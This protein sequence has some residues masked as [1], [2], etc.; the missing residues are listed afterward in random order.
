MLKENDMDLSDIKINKDVPIDNKF[1]VLFKKVLLKELP[2]YKALIKFEG[3]RP[4]SDYL[5]KLHSALVQ[6]VLQGITVG[7]YPYLHVYQK[8]N[9]FIMSDDYQTYYTYLQLKKS[10]IPCIVLGTE[11][12]GKFV[13]EKGCADY[14]YNMF[15]EILDNPKRN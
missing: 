3:I 2:F 9:Y 11:P 13:L 4:F 10:V 1:G 6:K 8:S 12:K 7:R 14:D 5:P 15:I